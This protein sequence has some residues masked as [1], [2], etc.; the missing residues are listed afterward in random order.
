MKRIE[1]GKDTD[2]L[3]ADDLDEELFADMG[4]NPFS[5][6]GYGI[7]SKQNKGSCARCWRAE[8]TFRY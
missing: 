7:K 1:K 4:I 8:K 3:E 5:R 2:D 6:P